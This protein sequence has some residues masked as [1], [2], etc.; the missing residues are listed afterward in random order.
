MKQLENSTTANL[1]TWPAQVRDPAH[2]ILLQPVN[3]RGEKHRMQAS[4]FKWATAGLSP[5]NMERTGWFH[6]DSKN[7][8]QCLYCSTV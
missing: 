8:T 2:L 4:R 7:R 3:L 6:L 5:E 1:A